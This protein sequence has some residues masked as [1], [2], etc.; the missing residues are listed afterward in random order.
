M[1][2]VVYLAGLLVVAAVAWA[3][4]HPL[5]APSGARGA[6]PMLDPERYRLEKQRD[7]AYAAIK[8]A[9]FDHQMGKLSA[10]DYA[11][12]RRKYEDRALDAL[13]ALERLG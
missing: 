12:L 4:A 2:T 7:L 6:R 11:L 9:E 5:L 1:S 10:D 3:V 8:E 13:A